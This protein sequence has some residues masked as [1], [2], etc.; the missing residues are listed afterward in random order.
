MTGQELMTPA[1]E[2][3]QLRQQLLQAQRLSSV[4][5]IASSVAHEFNN[6]LTMIINYAKMAMKPGTDEATRIQSLEKI[7]KGGLRAATIIQSML[8]F[9]RNNSTRRDMVDLVALVEEVLILAEKDL[10]KHRIQI[11]KKFQGRPQAPVIPAQIEQVLLNL[12]INSRQAMPRGGRLLLEVRENPR[13]EMAEILVSDTGIGIPPEQLRMIFEPFFT[14][15]EPDEHGHGGTG[16]GLS[17]CRQIIEQHSGRIR[18]ESKVGKGSTFIVKLP[19]K[20]EATT[21]VPPA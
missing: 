13:T 14:T 12:V 16:L 19:L 7:C 9:A 1:S 6:I 20:A 18:V 21:E 15:K 17:V 8:G 2:T 5:A 3:D 11:E 4:G 10:S